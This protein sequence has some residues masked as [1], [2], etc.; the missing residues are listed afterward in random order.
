MLVNLPEA[1]DP[2]HHYRLEVPARQGW[3]TL[4]QRQHWAEKADLTRFYRQVGKLR[5]LELWIP[6]IGQAHVVAE[7]RFRDRR[8]RDPHNWMPT[9]KA[10]LDGMV[11]AGVFPDDNHAHVI[12]PDMRIGPVA[13]WPVLIMHVWPSP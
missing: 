2:P 11:D 5:S 9:A 10:V 7:L 3:I 12:G 1:S 4:N 6:H 8:R 13:T